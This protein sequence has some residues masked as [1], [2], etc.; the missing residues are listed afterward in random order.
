MKFVGFVP[1]M[2]VLPTAIYTSG[3]IAIKR[4][5]DVSFL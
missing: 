5:T 1:G 2:K 3:G 4:K